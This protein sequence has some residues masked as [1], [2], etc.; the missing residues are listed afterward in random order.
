[1]ESI[2]SKSLDEIAAEMNAAVLEVA[3][4]VRQLQEQLN[5]KR[6]TAKLA[7]NLKVFGE[8]LV[9][10]KKA[11]ETRAN[12]DRI[13]ICADHVNTYAVAIMQGATA[14]TSVSELSN[15]INAISVASRKLTATTVEREIIYDPEEPHSAN[16]LSELVPNETINKIVEFE[17]RNR[18]LKIENEEHRKAIQVNT[19]MLAEVEAKLGSLHEQVKEKLGQVSVLYDSTLEELKKKEVQIA[20][21]VGVAS[22][23]VIAGSYEKSAADEKK[24]ADYLRFGSL[25]CMVAILAVVAYSFFETTTA[26]FKLETSIFRLI[27]A[28]FL[29]IPAAYLARESTKHRQQ[30]Y[31]HLQTSLDLKAITP[32]IASLPPDDQHKLKSEIANRLFAAKNYDHVGQES[33][34]INTHEILITL[35]NKLE[36]PSKKESEQKKKT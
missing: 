13:R 9:D 20:D 26:T 11:Y 25:T 14:N 33:Y 30:Q 10:F 34:P 4:A 32:Y 31:S 27:F 2:E 12:F 35:L 21:L 7:E 1:M 24:M 5:G 3:N 18:E 6:I 8:R 19:Q 36:F 28:V 23:N 16:Q 17:R 22:G 15:F 29:S